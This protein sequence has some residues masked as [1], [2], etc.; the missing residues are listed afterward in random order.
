M[1]TQSTTKTAQEDRTTFAVAMVLTGVAIIAT[2]DLATKWISSDLSI[3]QLLF[4]RSAFGLILLLPLLI[5]LKQLRI[6]KPLN[7]KRVVIRSLLMSLSYLAFFTALAAIP[8]ALVA[9]GFFSSPLF[10]VLL[11]WLMLNEK[12]GKWRLISVLSGFIGVL[13]ILRPDA[14][15]FDWFTALP[16]LAGF[17][18]A[19]T[20]IY[21][22]KYCK[23]E[24]A[25]ALSFWLTT[26]FM[27]V[28]LAGMLG[29][30]FLPAAEQPGFLNYPL[31]ITDQAITLTLIAVAIGSLAMHF[32]LAAAYQNAPASLIAPLEYLYMP[33]AILG[34]F[35][36]FDETPH[37]AAILGIAIIISAGLIITWRE[38]VQRQK[39]LHPN[40]ITS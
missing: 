4:M 36:F 34:G 26:V 29:L 6:I 31:I 21:T 16:V 25:L 19:A 38:R 3:W 18:Y 20:Q 13:L 27:I 39:V 23:N 17:F 28:G 37:L 2:T 33:L 5:T 10:M 9:G 32:S 15:S 40:R 35:V 22:R 24:H 8:V 1:T 12:I 7:F 30:Y 11:S 14:A